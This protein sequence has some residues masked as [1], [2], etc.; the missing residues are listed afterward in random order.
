MIIVMVI[1]WELCISKGTNIEGDGEGVLI[2][3]M[4]SCKTEGE[5]EGDGGDKSGYSDKRI[6]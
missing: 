5:S 1:E 6:I 2:L 3:V 4:M